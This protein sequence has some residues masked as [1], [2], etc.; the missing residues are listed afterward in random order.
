MRIQE[1]FLC[2]ILNN[3]LCCENTRCWIIYRFN[4]SIIIF[5][6][7]FLFSCESPLYSKYFREN[8][9]L[10]KHS[11][12]FYYIY[13]RRILHNIHYIYIHTQTIRQNIIFNLFLLQVNYWCFNQEIQVFTIYI[14]TFQQIGKSKQKFKREKKRKKYFLFE[15]RTQFNFLF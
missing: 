14:T 10:F 1:K 6:F 12:P 3:F 8:H 9:C 7:A 15:C 5:R 11:L 4:T 13:W 2:K